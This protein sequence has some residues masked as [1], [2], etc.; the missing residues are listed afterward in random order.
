MEYF[1]QFPQILY[2]FDPNKVEFSSVVDIFARVKM[3]DDVLKNSLVY[4]EYSVQDG[5]T[6]EIIAHKYYGDSKRHW[7]VMFSNQIIDPYFDFP[8]TQANLERNIISKYG[9]LA[10]SQTI[11]HHVEQRTVVVTNSSGSF[12]TEKYVAILADPYTYD[13][14]TH[15]L[16]SQP[17]PSVVPGGS[18]T[19][20]SIQLSSTTVTVG[21]TSVT[22]TV[23]LYAIS[24]YSNEV[25]V[26]ES[27][28]KIRLVDKQYVTILEQQLQSLLSQ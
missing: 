4:Y 11:L 3:L 6:P 19:D 20:S 7:I 23:T 21:N 18:E 13:F 16:V 26:N 14:S 5:D 12:T 8:L 17:Y 27:K 28:R 24:N 22:T 2:T 1:A 9:S 15:H 25:A 10:N